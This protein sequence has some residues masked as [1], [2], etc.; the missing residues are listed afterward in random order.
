M[1]RRTL[2]RALGA[3]GLPGSLTACGGGGAAS[4]PQV[5]PI[6]ARID[7]IILDKTGYFVGDSARLTA[8]FSGT[9]RLEP[10]AI[11]V[12]SDVALT[13]GPLTKNT[14]YTLVVTSGQLEVKQDIL[15][16]VAYRHTFTTLQMGP[17]RAAHQAVLL[18]DGRVLLLGGEGNGVA[19]PTSVVAFNWQTRA[20]AT[21]GDLLTGRTEHTA[22][23]LGDGTVL[24]VGGSRNV[25]GTPLAERFDPRTGVSR[26]TA[27][28]PVDNRWQHTATLLPDSKVLIAGGRTSSAN[29]SSDTM[30]LFDPATDQFTRLPAR[31]AFKRYG[32]VAVKVTDTTVILYGGAS[33]AGAS[34]PPEEFDI[35]SRT[36]QAKAARPGDPATRMNPAMVKLANSDVLVA[37]GG[38]LP[39]YTPLASVAAIAVGGIAINTM[40]PMLAARTLL[41]GATLA[42]GRALLAGGAID[43]PSG[44]P[45]KR[46]VALAST[47]LYALQPNS[48]QAGPAMATGRYSHTATALPN[49]MV[50]MAGGY[51]ADGIALASAELYS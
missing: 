44:D 17:A 36:T 34:V 18:A 43:D 3:V 9:G 13:L 8:R 21:I 39:N 27:G 35:P 23:A 37:G 1:K 42:D 50:L 32:H 48:V 12:I 19:S 28:Q 41:A 20:F 10:G 11:A 49:G 29:G 40:A 38:L 7:S 22:T 4:S 5:N 6:A 14:T 24:V 45:T 26:A 51:G 47:E 25:S 31:L 2:L 33:T 30:D 15:V 46:P 16:P